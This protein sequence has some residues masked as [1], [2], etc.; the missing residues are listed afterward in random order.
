M[1]PRFCDGGA[2]KQI[3]KALLLVCLLA[4]GIG[5]FAQSSAGTIGGSVKD[6]QGAVLP[7]A[8]VTFTNLGTNRTIE[9]KSNEDGLFNLPALDPGT[10]KIDVKHAN[11]RTSTRQVT[12]QTAQVLNLDF[13]LQPG[14]VSET[15]EVTAGTPVVDTATS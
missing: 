1:K 3:M 14:A 6:S 7:D 2:M 8:S 13:Q 4:F 12:L 11:F 10:Y 15:I 5:A 9:M